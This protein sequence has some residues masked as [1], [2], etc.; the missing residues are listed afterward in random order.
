MQIDYDYDIIPKSIIYIKCS[1]D[2]K[3]SFLLNQSRVSNYS[4]LLK[5]VYTNSLLKWN[6]LNEDPAKMN[7]GDFIKNETF[8]FYEVY[9]FLGFNLFE[10]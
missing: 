4:I 8:E 7:I 6:K 10:K 9:N 3:S 1:E 2:D 5:E